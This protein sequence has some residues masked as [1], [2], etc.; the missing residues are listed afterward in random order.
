MLEIPYTGPLSPKTFVR[1]FVSFNT[2]LYNT[3]LSVSNRDGI[4]CRRK[5]AI[6]ALSCVRF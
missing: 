2:P 6:I 3:D 4:K 5:V 1:I